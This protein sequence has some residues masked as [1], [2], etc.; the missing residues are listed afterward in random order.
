[1]TVL[2]PEFLCVSSVL[3]HDS[4]LELIERS[5]SL[6]SDYRVGGVSK[7]LTSCREVIGSG[8]Y[9]PGEGGGPCH[10]AGGP[11]HTFPTR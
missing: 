6:S 5:F 2:R 1:M 4:E 7:C 9:C 8:I 11:H 3:S 10:G